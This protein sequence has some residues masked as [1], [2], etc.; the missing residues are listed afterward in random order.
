MFALGFFVK[1]V[2]I[3]MIGNG[4]KISRCRLDVLP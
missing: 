2:L 1:F 3:G 4:L